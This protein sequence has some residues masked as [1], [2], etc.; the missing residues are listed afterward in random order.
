LR[1][2]RLSSKFESTKKDDYGEEEALLVTQFKGK[3]Q[4]WGK[5]GHKSAQCKSKMVQEDLEIICNYYK[6]SGHLKSNCFK[7]LR[8][9]QA[10]GSHVGIRNEIAGS[11]AD[12]ILIIM[13]ANDKIDSKVGIGNS[14]TWRQRLDTP[15]KCWQI[16][17]EA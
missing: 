12:V 9:N 5:L 15:R 2:E 17:M 4:N 6:K 3:C 13:T 1:F 11:A 16:I 10:E 8:K 7:L 14:G